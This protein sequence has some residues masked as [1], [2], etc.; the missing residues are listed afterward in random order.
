M[1]IITPD[2]EML[3]PVGG[4]NKK[5]KNVGENQLVKLTIGNREVQEL[6]YKGADF[7][8]TGIARFLKDDSNF[9]LI[10]A[11]FTWARAFSK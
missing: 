11:K 9:N 4:M 6:N 2:G 7:L 3:I 1:L 10:N 8:I 5:E